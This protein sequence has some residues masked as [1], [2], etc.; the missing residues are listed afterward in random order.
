MTWKT[1][2]CIPPTIIHPHKRKIHPLLS[3]SPTPSA[4]SLH[5]P[6]LMPRHPPDPSFLPFPWKLLT[7]P[8]PA[9]MSQATTSLCYAPA[10]SFFNVSPN[11]APS[12]SPTCF[13]N[14]HILV[15]I[16]NMSEHLLFARHHSNCLPR[17]SS[18]AFT[19]VLCTHY[20]HCTV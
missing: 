9:E 14:F 4:G 15:K 20:V 3:S 6:G 2:A 10:W 11:F 8:G 5:C 17:I 1:R 7:P 19:I 16:T 12:L 18:L 13:L